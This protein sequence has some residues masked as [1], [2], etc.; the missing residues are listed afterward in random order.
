MTSKALASCGDYLDHS[1]LKSSGLFVAPSDSGS[2]D[3]PT[4]SCKNGRCR[5]APL[6]IPTEPS[7]VIVLRQQPSHL[8]L[9][10]FDQACTL[11]G[12]LTSGNDSLPVEPSLDLPDPP[13][14]DSIL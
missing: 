12:W 2:D 11:T 10:N 8:R 3:S 14:R 7:R 9:Y 4:P 1:K 5:S 13:P 6:T